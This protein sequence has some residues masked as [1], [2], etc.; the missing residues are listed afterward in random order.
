MV[1][2]SIVQNTNVLDSYVSNECHSE[3]MCMAVLWA[4][5]WVN[6]V[7][8]YYLKIMLVML[9]IEDTLLVIEETLRTTSVRN[10]VHLCSHSNE[11][12][13]FVRNVLTPGRKKI[14]KRCQKYC[15]L[16]EFHSLVFTQSKI[17]PS[18]NGLKHYYR[19]Q[20]QRVSTLQEVLCL[21]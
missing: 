5:Q 21:L 19:Q 3:Y 10:S 1:S 16:I 2:C 20:E 6:R 12:V 4:I 18:Q 17:L 8:L 7:V 15:F 13:P 9:I 11:Q 14:S